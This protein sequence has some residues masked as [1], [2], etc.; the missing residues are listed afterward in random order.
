MANVCYAI[1]EDYSYKGDH[2]SNIVFCTVYSSYE[3]VEAQFKRLVKEMKESDPDY[4]DVDCHP[5]L[6]DNDRE[7][8][9]GEEGNYNENHYSL[10]LIELEVR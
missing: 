3:S 8:S 1:L 2:E 7:F 6:I 5:T 10:K 4:L 9:F